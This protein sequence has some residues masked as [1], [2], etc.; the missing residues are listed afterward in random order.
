MPVRIEAKMRRIEPGSQEAW[1]H[2]RRLVEE[3]AA[4]LDL[5]LSVQDFAHEVEHLEREHAAPAGASLLAEENGMFVGCVGLR[6]SSPGVG[7]IKRL[8]AVPAARGRGVG[9]FLA[10]GVVGEA[11]RLGYSRLL[12]DT[13]PNMKAAQALYVSLGFKPVAAYSF[14]PVEGTSYL[15]LNLR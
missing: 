5:D 9:R 11:K 10:E 14:N 6:Q 3:Y 4:S 15:E 2:A 8:Y 7:E 12:L 1:L 13:L